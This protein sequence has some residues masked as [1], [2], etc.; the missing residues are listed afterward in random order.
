MYSERPVSGMDASIHRPAVSMAVAL[1]AGISAGACAPG[2]GRWIAGAAVLCCVWLACNIVLHRRGAAGPVLTLA[3]IGYLSIQPW[4]TDAVPDHHISR[5]V[6]DRTFRISGVIVEEPDLFQG[7]WRFIMETH[8]LQSGRMHHIATGRVM[9]SGRG[10][11]PG[12]V[13]GDRVIF[14]GR[15]RRIRSFANPG[16]FDYERF[17]ALQAVRARVYAKAGSLRVL[18]ASNDGGWKRKLDVCRN[19]LADRMT[20]SLSG[21]PDPTVRLLRAILLGDKGQV[22]PQV[23]QAFN[24]AGVA[25]VLAISGLHIGMVAGVSFAVARWI[26]SWIPLMLRRA[27]TRR[28]AALFSLGPVIGYGLLAGLSPSTQRAMLMAVLFLLTF[29]VGRPHD[30]INPLA[31]AAL[32]IL[33]LHPPALLSISFQLSFMAVLAIL[34]GMSQSPSRTAERESPPVRRMLKRWGLL[35]RVTLLAVAG[36]LPLTLYYF[37]QVS[38]VGPVVNL[39]V[40]PL[41]GML[42]VPAGLAG[43]AASAVHSQFAVLLWHIAAMGME[44]VRILVEWTAQLPWSAVQTVTPTFFEICLYY[45]LIAV[46]LGWKRL[47]R[48]GAALAVILALSILDSGYWIH[49]RFGRRDLRVTV[50]DVG[51]GTANLVQFPGGY[52]ALIDGGGFSDNTAFDVGARIVAPQLWRLKIA[53]VDLVVL[54]HADSDHLNGLLYILD[55]FNV[56]EVWSNGESSASKGSRQWNRSVDARQVKHLEWMHMPRVKVQ[57]GVRLKLL[58]PPSDFKQRIGERWR[59]SNNNS[60]VLHLSFGDVSF[61][62][63]G[64][65]MAAAEADLISRVGAGQLRSTVL[66]VPHHGSRRSSSKAFLAAV[67]PREAL[68]SAGWRNRFGFPHSDVLR[69]LEASGACIRCTADNGAI[70]VVTDGK[71][72]DIRTYRRPGDEG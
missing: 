41:T 17:M 4:L 67:Q 25:H 69:R 28:G 12:A 13:R 36:T 55:H 50:I 8:Q 71:D 11:W 22:S 59:D 7:R 2:Y 63:T 48:S 54:S 53:T 45:L 57:Q 46:M 9:V 5:F 30:W 31:V 1:V 60:L 18:S 65:I 61:L 27:W 58:A 39:F 37:N 29:W 32:T 20:R 33:W 40:V 35:V 62:F 64:D 72:Y 68:I 16:G 47:P 3:L 43:V 56:K 51:Q 23:R 21:Y 6:G 38:L 66:I 49:Q 15:L 10:A 24:R 26:L 19:Q 52:T 42:I 34:V 44:A 70:Q 14:Q